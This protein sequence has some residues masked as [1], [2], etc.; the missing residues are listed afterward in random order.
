MVSSRTPGNHGAKTALAGW[1]GRIRT[2]ASL[3]LPTCFVTRDAEQASFVREVQ[4]WETGLYRD[5]FSSPD[6]LRRPITG[7]LHEWELVRALTERKSKGLTSW[8]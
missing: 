2:S 3:A 1:G 8:A 7:R 6:Q 4:S 5:G